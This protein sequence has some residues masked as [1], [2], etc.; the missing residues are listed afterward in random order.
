MIDMGQ[1]LCDGN[2]LRT[3]L[4]AFVALDAFAGWLFPAVGDQHLFLLQSGS[5]IFIKRQMVHGG[6]GT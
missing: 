5:L 3:N 2:V 6:K 4:F 1:F